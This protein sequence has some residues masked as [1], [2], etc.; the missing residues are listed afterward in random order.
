M[1]H[2]QSFDYIPECI[3]GYATDNMKHN[4][5]WGRVCNTKGRSH[6]NIRLDLVNEHLKLDFKG[7]QCLVWLRHII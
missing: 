5:I 7:K 4:L 2:V 1:I 3:G 6:G